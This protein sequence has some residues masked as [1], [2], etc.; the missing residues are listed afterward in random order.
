MDIGR[1]GLALSLEMADGRRP[2]SPLR[3]RVWAGLNVHPDDPH[4]AQV[5]KAMVVE[6]DFGAAGFARLAPLVVVA[7]SEGDASAAA[8]VERSALTLAQMV[9]TINQRLLLEA[10]P[11]W[12]MGGALE[13][14]C[15]NAQLLAPAG[16]ACSGALALA[17]DCLASWGGD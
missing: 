2:E 11:V 15:P 14:S 8:V 1:D 12:P 7:A 5:I 10:P 16:D 9:A 17:R 4:A 6:P 13:R 3:A